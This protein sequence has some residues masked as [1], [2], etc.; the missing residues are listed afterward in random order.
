MDLLRDEIPHAAV[1][2]S[3]ALALGLPDSQQHDDFMGE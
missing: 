2:V 3:P 1:V